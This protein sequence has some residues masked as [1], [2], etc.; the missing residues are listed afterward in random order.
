[1]PL[2][3][4][5]NV[6]AVRRRNASHVIAAQRRLPDSLSHHASPGRLP[7]PRCGVASRPTWTTNV[8]G[9][10]PAKSQPCR[11]LPPAHGS[12]RS[13]PQAFGYPVQARLGL[14]A[15]TIPVIRMS[16]ARSATWRSASS[17]SRAFFLCRLAR[18]SASR[19]VAKQGSSP[20][21]GRSPSQHHYRS[22]RSSRT[23]P[24]HATAPSLVRGPYPGFPNET[25]RRP[26]TPD[27]R[28]RLLSDVPEA[29]RYQGER[30]SQGKTRR[31]PAP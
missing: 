10:A 14:R 7:G 12:R 29:L 13:S 15:T 4:A 8:A 31:S 18:N 30:H 11:L 17:R 28:L 3:R 21:Q 5:R 20:S 24:L 27:Q 23:S 1:M 26:W 16:P 2:R 19:S 6:A 22:Y 25:S 9:L